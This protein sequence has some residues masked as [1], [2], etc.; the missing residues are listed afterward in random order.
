MR[1]RSLGPARIGDLV[2]PIDEHDFLFSVPDKIASEEDPI[3][4]IWNDDMPGIVVEVLDLDPP[5]EYYQIRII[6][7]EIVGWTYSDYVWVVS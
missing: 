7:G 6:V 3:D 4:M 5:R 2:L 1:G